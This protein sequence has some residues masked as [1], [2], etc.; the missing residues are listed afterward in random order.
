MACD[1]ARNLHDNNCQRQKCKAE[2]KKTYY[3]IETSANRMLRPWLNLLKKNIIYREKKT[4]KSHVW[5]TQ[6]P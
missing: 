4:V 6:V 3:V 1:Y 2:Q 5:I